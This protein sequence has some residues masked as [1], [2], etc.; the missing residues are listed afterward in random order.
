VSPATLAAYDRGVN[1]GVIAGTNEPDVGESDVLEMGRPEHDRPRVPDIVRRRLTPR[2]P[3]G[4]YSWLATGGVVLVAAILRLIGLSHPPGKIFD[5]TYYATEGAT[6]F[7]HGIEWNLENDGPK[8]V[9]HPPLGKWIIGLGEWMFGENEF[10]WRIAS[11]VAGVLSILIVVRIGRRLFRSTVLG[12]AAGLLMCLD[13]MH[14]VLSRSALLDIFLMLF[15]VAAFGCLVMDRDDRRRRWLRALDAGLDPT[16]SGPAGRP[17]LGVPVWRLAAGLMIGCGCAVKWSA[18]WY[19]PLFVVLVYFWEVS[20]RR[21]A[22]VPHPWRDAF[23][24]EAGWAAAFVGLAVTAYL[25]SWTGW[26]LSDNGWDRH[27]LQSQGHSE[28]PIIGALYNLYHYHQT[29][30]DFHTTLTQKHTYQSWPWQWLLLARPVAFYYSGD[31]PCGAA[32]C[33]SEVLLLGTPLLWW[34]FLPAL[35]GLT[36]FGISRRDWRAAAIGLCA[37]AGIVPWFWNELDSRTMF[38]FYAL[39]AEPFLVLAVVYVLGAFIGP[40]PPRNQAAADRRLIGSVAAGVYFGLVALC[41]L[42][43]YP[44]YTGEVITYTQWWARMF[45]GTRWV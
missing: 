11:V 7:H 1:V 18:I 28:P 5:E 35:A 12:C 39:P 37:A 9:V 8:Y 2:L 26:F 14:F 41:F 36:W 23:L 44:I 20:T 13:G 29:A 40:A 19:I 17:R 34:S 4:L 3:D 27:Y 16:R 43:F 25:A 31:G 30:W 33:S 15:V 6:L 45:L 10:G 22:G 32:Q 38:Y 42:Y 21:S 24:D